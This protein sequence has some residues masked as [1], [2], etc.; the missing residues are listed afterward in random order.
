MW[1]WRITF[2]NKSPEY[3]SHIQYKS[4]DDMFVYILAS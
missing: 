4:D 2:V 1:Y 3:M